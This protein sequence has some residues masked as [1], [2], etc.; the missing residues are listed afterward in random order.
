MKGLE[1]DEIFL[2]EL[3]KGHNW[4]LW[5]GYLLLKEGFAVRVSSLATRP[6]HDSID[7]YGDDGD[8]KVTFPGKTVVLEVKSRNL[9]FTSIDDY[10]YQ[11]AFVDRVNTWRRKADNKPVAIC[12]VSQPTGAIVVVPTSSESSWL[13]ETVRDRVREYDRDYYLVNKICLARWESLL[14]WLKKQGGGQ[15]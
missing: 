9:Y 5:V 4:Q 11:T 12:L 1:T 2:R 10:P 15:E 6:D 13:V 8:V 14:T 3:K 7:L